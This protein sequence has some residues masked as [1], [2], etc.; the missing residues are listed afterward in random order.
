MEALIYTHGHLD[1][2]GGTSAFVGNNKDVKII[3]REGFKDELQEHSPV[4]PILKQR[5][6]RQFGRD[7]PAN[8]IINRG[9][10]R[11]LLQQTEREKDIYRPTSLF[12][13]P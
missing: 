11:V 12:K 5:N 4:E 10:A 7:L 6:I 9:V 8:E 2:T 13:T 3:A 1:H